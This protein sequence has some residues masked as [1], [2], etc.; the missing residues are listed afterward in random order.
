MA[1]VLAEAGIIGQELADRFKL[2]V[3]FRNR[4]VHMYWKVDDELVC[5]YL[6]KN[7]EDIS[8]LAKVFAKLS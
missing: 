1:Q 4:L 7:L 3:S 2:M 5:D 6:E 8:E